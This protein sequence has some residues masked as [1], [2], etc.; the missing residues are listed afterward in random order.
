[1]PDTGLTKPQGARSALALV[2]RCPPTDAT[3]SRYRFANANRA[4]PK[5]AAALTLVRVRVA[6]R[7]EAF[8]REDSRSHSTEASRVRRCTLIDG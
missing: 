5:R 7:R 6:S 2:G 8:R 4:A 3:H 1:M